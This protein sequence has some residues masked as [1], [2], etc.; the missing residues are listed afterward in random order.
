[1]ELSLSQ[2]F[3]YCKAPGLRFTYNCTTT[4][5]CFT[6]YYHQ[7]KVLNQFQ[8][9][10]KAC[11]NNFDLTKMVSN[12]CLEHQNKTVSVIYNTLVHEQS[13]NPVKR[14]RNSK[15]ELM[16]PE[17]VISN[18]TQPSI[19]QLRERCTHGVEVLHAGLGKPLNNTVSV[20]LTL[21]SVV[22]V[23]SRNITLSRLLS[24]HLPTTLLMP[25]AC[26]PLPRTPEHSI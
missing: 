6:H 3:V 12:A 7:M 5:S 16:F 21:R 11:S 24:L 17:I 10:H 9:E 18:Q 4:D 2:V 8:Y 22:P 1:M 14:Q 20:P 23:P 25:H 19:D 26:S 15:L 13:I